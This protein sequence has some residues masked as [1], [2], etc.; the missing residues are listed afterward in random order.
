[1]KRVALL[2]CVILLACAADFSGGNAYGQQVSKPGKR[3]YPKPVADAPFHINVNTTAAQ[4]ASGEA[5]A[6]ETDGPADAVAKMMAKVLRVYHIQ[7]SLELKA[8][9]ARGPLSER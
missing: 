1:M 2:L 9:R 5:T 8:I 3:A 7:N 6:D 4:T